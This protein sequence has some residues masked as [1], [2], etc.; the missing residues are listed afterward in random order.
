MDARDATVPS[1][2]EAPAEEPESFEAFFERTHVRLFRA[3]YLVLGRAGEA[4]DV[5]Q[6]SFARVWERWDRVRAMD[7]PAGYLFRVA[8]NGARS[9]A[10]RAAVAAKLGVVQTRRDLFEE[11]D[12]RD[13][14]VRGLRAL[15]PRTRAALV[16]TELLD[17]GSEDAAR[18][19]GVRP[20]SVRS[21][22]SRG[23]SALRTAL[24]DDDA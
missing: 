4:E 17:F 7:S 6:E 5:M 12:A 22:A 11:V 19:M 2:V 24:E 18:I 21:L 10:R 15:T 16:L 1:T 14:V 9:R 23:R 20:A 13:A 8:M 3:L